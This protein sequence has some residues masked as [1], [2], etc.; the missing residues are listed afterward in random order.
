MLY[1][2]KFVF[3]YYMVSKIKN[4]NRFHHLFVLPADYPYKK[5]R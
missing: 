1:S 2:I 3:T 5:K 4:K